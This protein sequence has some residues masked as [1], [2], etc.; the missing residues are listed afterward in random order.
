MQ[1]GIDILVGT[2]AR[3]EDHLQN[4]KLDLTK[5]W[6]VVLDEDDQMFDTGFEDQMEETL[7]IAYKND[8]EGNP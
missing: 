1:S 8:S 5:L 6:C 2:P 7:C 4:G 3:I